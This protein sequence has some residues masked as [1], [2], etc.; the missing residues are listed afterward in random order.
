MQEVC[1]E[2]AEEFREEF[3]QQGKDVCAV[4]EVLSKHDVVLSELAESVGRLTSL[5]LAKVRHQDP[6]PHDKS[7]IERDD[8]MTVDGDPHGHKLASF[9]KLTA[10]LPSSLLP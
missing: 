7:L 10:G 4:R 5:T 2:F 3:R 1:A 9:P 6:R 8:L